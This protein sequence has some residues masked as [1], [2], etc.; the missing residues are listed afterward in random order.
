MKIS[1][2]ISQLDDYLRL[3]KP[4]KFNT[5]YV[6]QEADKILISF[7]SGKKVATI[8]KYK[9]TGKNKT[10]GV[11]VPRGALHEQSVYGK[12]KVVEKDKA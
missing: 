3:Q 8:T 4:V 12:I 7:K 1:E 2:R 9:A 10:T 5:K 6:E 11:I